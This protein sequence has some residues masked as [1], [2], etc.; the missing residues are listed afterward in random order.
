[1][2]VTAVLQ[3]ATPHQL[4]YLVTS[5]VAGGTVT[6]GSSGGATPDL[7]TDVA[8][9]TGPMKRIGRAGLDGIGLIAAGG[10]D[11]VAKSN[12]LLQNLD[13]TSV[14]GNSTVPRA[15]MDCQGQTVDDEWLVTTTVA[16]GNPQVSVTHGAAVATAVLT[17]STPHSTAI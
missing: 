6:I 8:T 2:A 3:R 17:I 16:G 15:T 4:V 5:D 13:P 14:L 9:T 11:A 1:M 7:A 12:A 10:F